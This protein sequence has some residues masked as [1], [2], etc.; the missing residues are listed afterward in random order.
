MLFN[1]YGPTLVILALTVDESSRGQAGDSGTYG[2]THTD[3]HTRVKTIPLGQ[4][5]PWVIKTDKNVS[6]NHY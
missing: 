4:N 2:H 3:T 6:F 1:N 5:C